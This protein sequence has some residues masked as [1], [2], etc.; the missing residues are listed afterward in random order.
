MLCCF[1]AVS[2]EYA[3]TN[4]CEQY[5]EK[6]ALVQAPVYRVTHAPMDLDCILVPSEVARGEVRTSKSIPYPRIRKWGKTTT[7]EKGYDR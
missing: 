3:Q 6:I 5:T 4:R 2:C 7:R 1:Q